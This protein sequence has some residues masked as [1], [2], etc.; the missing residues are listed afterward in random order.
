M[1]HPNEAWFPCSNLIF[2]SK[3]RARVSRPISNISSI[4]STPWFLRLAV[5]FVVTECLEC[6][7]CQHY[8]L[9]EPELPSGVPEPVHLLFISGLDQLVVDHEERI[10]RHVIREW[11]KCSQSGHIVEEMHKSLTRAWAYMYHGR[12]PVTRTILVVETS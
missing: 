4:S 1:T 5:T 10:R 8:L 11:R 6:Y 9:P 7:T 3:E 2:S 12:G